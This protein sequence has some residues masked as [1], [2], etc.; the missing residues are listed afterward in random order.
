M[1]AINGIV[2]MAIGAGLIIVSSAINS[3]KL[4]LFVWLGVLLGVYG[5]GKVLWHLIMKERKKIKKIEKK[6]AKP[7]E[8][9]ARAVYRSVCHKCGHAVHTGQNFCHICGERLVHHRR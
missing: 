8:R 2:Y 6:I 5:L 1:K 3:D 9:E 7:V 4:V